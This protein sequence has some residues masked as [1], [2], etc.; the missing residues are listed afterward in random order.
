MTALKHFE[1]KSTRQSRWRRSGSC[2][3]SVLCMGVKVS[4]A[5]AS[6]LYWSSVDLVRSSHWFRSG[7]KSAWS[8]QS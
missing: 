1:L 7:Q 3:R 5:S 4:V 6:T 8:D 2:T